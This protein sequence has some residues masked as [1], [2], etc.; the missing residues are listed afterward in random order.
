MK[1]LLLSFSLIFLASTSYAKTKVE[2]KFDKIQK[3]NT[4]INKLYKEIEIINYSIEQESSNGRNVEKLYSDLDI[5]YEKIGKIE[6][7]INEELKDLSIKEK[8]EI[9]IK[10]A[11]LQI[12][13]DKNE[14]SKIKEFPVKIINYYDKAIELLEKDLE[15]LKISDL[16]SFIKTF[17]NRRI[18]KFILI[19]E[20][21][22]N[23]IENRPEEASALF[24]TSLFKKS[25]LE[26]FNFADTT[27]F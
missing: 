25:S 21:Q 14:I 17:L 10:M 9:S 18:D 26:I 7:F 20:N 16:K 22:L 23:E 8:I 2:A 4:E 13:L 12:Q 5:K 1:K 19:T 15:S 3:K 6:N 24:F 11:I 27:Y